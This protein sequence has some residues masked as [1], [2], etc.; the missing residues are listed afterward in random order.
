MKELDLL[1]ERFVRERFE[2]APP[3]LKRAFERLLELPDPLLAELL[4]GGAEGTPA[5][6]RSG[7]EPA[8]GIGDE[9]A[10]GIAPAGDIAGD[11]ALARAAALVA[12]LGR[13]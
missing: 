13:R 6:D 10:W 1:L 11:T 9:A 3:E 5:P 8:C 4:L 7:R 2:D 12:A